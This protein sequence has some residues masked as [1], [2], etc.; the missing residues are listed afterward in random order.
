MTVATQDKQK[1]YSSTSEIF[2]TL[3]SKTHNKI[4]H[5][6]N[7]VTKSTCYRMLCM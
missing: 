2:V 4:G 6:L 7:H 1:H 5:S 3:E